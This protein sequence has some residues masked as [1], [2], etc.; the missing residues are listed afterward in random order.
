MKFALNLEETFSNDANINCNIERDVLNLVNPPVSSA[1][2]PLDYITIKEVNDVIRTLKIRPGHDNISA[3]II[4]HLPREAVAL[5][6][7]TY[8]SCLR[9]GSFPKAWKKAEIIP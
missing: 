1:E 9:I 6:T 7:A 8:N 4:K 2:L 5:L 3:T